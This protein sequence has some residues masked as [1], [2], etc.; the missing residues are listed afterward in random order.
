MRRLSGLQATPLS[1]RRVEVRRRL[2]SRAAVSMSHRSLSVALS[3]Y[4]GSTT[5]ATIQRPSGLTCGALM[6]FMS[7]TSSWVGARFG[8][9]AAASGTARDANNH[10][11]EGFMEPHGSANCSAILHHLD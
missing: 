10:A 11:M 1:G 7:Q 8:A 3:S 6:R 9:A 5:E 2:R 4:E